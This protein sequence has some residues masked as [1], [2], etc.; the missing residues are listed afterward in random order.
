MFVSL[1]AVISKSF[2][3]SPV[4]YLRSISVISIGLTHASTG[5]SPIKSAVFLASN[6]TA[7][8]IIRQM[9]TATNTTKPVVTVPTVKSK[10][11]S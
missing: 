11:L 1:F 8:L 6:Q 2:E 4:H 10:C 3:P 7:H 5:I 9:Y